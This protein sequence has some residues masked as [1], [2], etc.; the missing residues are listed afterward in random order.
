M[1]RSRSPVSVFGSGALRRLLACS[2]I[3]QFPTRLPRFSTPGT[4][5]MAAAVAGSSIPLSAISRASLRMGESRRLTVEEESPSA[6]SADRYCWTRP[7]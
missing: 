4:R 1:A 3:S 7:W 6:R 5:S 2:F